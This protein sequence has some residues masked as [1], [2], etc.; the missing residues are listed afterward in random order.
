MEVPDPYPPPFSL[1]Q[2]NTHTSLCLSLECLCLCGVPTSTLIKF[3]FLLLIYLMSFFFL[4]CPERPWTPARTR[5]GLSWHR[6]NERASL[7]SSILQM[8]GHENPNPT[9]WS[10]GLRAKPPFQKLTPPVIPLAARPVYQN[11]MPILTSGLLCY[12]FALSRR[13]CQSPGLTSSPRIS[14]RL[15]W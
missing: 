12:S 1:V 3:D 5:Q 2:N 13:V 14:N 10:Q 9:P 11:S 4:V 7:S 15:F 6:L 8:S